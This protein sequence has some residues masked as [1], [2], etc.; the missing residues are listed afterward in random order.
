MIDIIVAVRS[1]K[2]SSI[3]DQISIHGRHHVF[4]VSAAPVVRRQ[5]VQT[6][7]P[8]HCWRM[9]SIQPSTTDRQY[10]GSKTRL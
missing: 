5:M 10:A 2:Q 6:D 9:S 1:S 4:I 8:H 7:Q 3:S